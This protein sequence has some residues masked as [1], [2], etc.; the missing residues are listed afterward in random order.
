MKLFIGDIF[1]F[2][3][4]RLFISFVVMCVMFYVLAAKLFDLQIINGEDFQFNLRA[5]FEQNISLKAT[6]GTIY[7]RTGR[8]LAVNESAFILKLDPSV[9]S[10]DINQKI[11]NM[12]DL[13]EKNGETYIDN[14]PITKE[15][16]FAFDFTG[17][18]TKESRWKR[19]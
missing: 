11:L 1:R 16:P 12:M 8:P 5:T 9:R 7:D 19:I 4:N 14:F 3:T 15:E 10:D 17:T 13:F 6:R 18:G 2:I